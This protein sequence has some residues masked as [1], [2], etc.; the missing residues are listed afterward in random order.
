MNPYTVLGVS[1]NASD[2]ELRSRYRE[3]ARQTHPDVNPGDAAA[4]ERFK[5]VSEA[6]A[7]LSDSEKR[8]AYDEFGDAALQSGFD[9]T[10]ARRARASFGGFGG[11]AGGGN[12]FAGADL[13][14][15]E[16]LLG[17]LFGRGAARSRGRAGADLEAD[18]E[19]DFLEA[20]TGGEQRLTINRP[21]ANGGSRTETVT[22]RIPAGVADGGRVRLRGKGAEGVGGGPPGD[23]YARIRVRPHPFFRREGRDLYVDVPV[24]I[25]EAVAGAKVLV[26]TLD[27]RVIVTI[28]PGTDSGTKLRL[29]G[30]G[31]PDPSGGAVGS[32]F[33]VVQ[34]RVPSTV[35][36]S[37]AETLEGLEELDLG[38]LREDLF[39]S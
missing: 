25:P 24:S 9:V 35:S 7:I 10:A 16:D 34:I 5:S 29:R 1:R 11:S 26:P 32:L 33:A 2:E 8:A 12:P 23:L 37:T 13:G 3:L 6:Y 30:K 15:F 21:T 31:V 18:L 22:V 17:G 38:D 19:L 39:S 36:A 14:G 20:A 27:G 28:P 4:E